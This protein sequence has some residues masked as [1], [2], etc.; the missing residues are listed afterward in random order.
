MTSFLFSDETSDVDLPIS[1]QQ[2]SGMKVI[3]LI[4]QEVQKGMHHSFLFNQ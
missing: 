1:M 2:D 4:A 3:G